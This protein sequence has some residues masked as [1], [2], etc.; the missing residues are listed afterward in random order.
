MTLEAIK[1]PFDHDAEPA[2][3]A[4]REAYRHIRRRILSGAFGPGH[5]INLAEVAD[6]LAI[7]RMPVREALRQLDAEG[8]MLMRPN[9]GAT[10][11]D[12]T[13]LEVEEYFQIRAVLEGLAAGL[14]AE[15]LTQEDIEQLT[16]LKQQM[17]RAVDDRP[18]WIERHRRFHE[19]ISGICGRPNLPREI[20][21]ITDLLTPRTAA[22]LALSG[23]EKLPGHEHDSVLDALC[24][25]DAAIAEVEMRRH[26][27]AAS[28]DVIA[29]MHDRKQGPA[30]TARRS[31]TAAHR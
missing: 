28:R 24:S 1:E 8:M 25:G 18:M 6:T 19:L 23:I 30:K 5:R 21:R 26:I 31:D 15:R 7:S 20:A 2:A 22:H 9:R 14:A 29:H 11:V 17:C 12:L 13:P 3:T 16:L 4:Q 10:V 27:L